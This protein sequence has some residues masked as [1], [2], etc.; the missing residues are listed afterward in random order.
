ML[1]RFGS[2][3]RRSLKIAGAMAALVPLTVAAALVAS[4]AGAD[5]APRR[6]RRVPPRP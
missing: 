3:P 2:S 4:P 5:V 6:P 1:H